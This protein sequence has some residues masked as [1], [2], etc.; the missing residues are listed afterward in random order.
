MQNLFHGKDTLTSFDQRVLSTIGPTD[1]R[2]GIT[3]NANS[4]WFQYNI[5]GRRMSHPQMIQTTGQG[6]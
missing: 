4:D 5:G 6:K 1:R 3:S 2:F